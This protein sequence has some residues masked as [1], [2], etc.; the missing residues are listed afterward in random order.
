MKSL[1]T[2]LLIINIIFIIN[3]RK[4][5]DQCVYIDDSYEHVVQS[6]GNGRQSFRA[7]SIFTIDYV[8]NAKD[9]S[10]VVMFDSGLSTVNYIKHIQMGTVIREEFKE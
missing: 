5:N 6:C 2:I 10:M 8:D 9:E 3:C 7:G 1:L 4:W